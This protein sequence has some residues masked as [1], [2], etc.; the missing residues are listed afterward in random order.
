MNCAKAES[1]SILHRPQ[2]L[3]QPHEPVRPARVVEVVP[4]LRGKGTLVEHELRG[5]A[6]DAQRNRD[7][8]LPIVG[9]GILPAK[10]VREPVRRIDLAKLSCQVEE[11]AFG[12][13]H[14]DPISA[15][16]AEVAFDAG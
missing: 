8:R 3:L 10:R 4:R 15:A 1:P 2:C 12:R 16:D 6:D 5:L 14:R 13:Q 7:D 9:V 11:L